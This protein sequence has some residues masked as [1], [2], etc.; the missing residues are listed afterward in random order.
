MQIQYSLCLQELFPD[1]VLTYRDASSYARLVET[2]GEGDPDI[3]TED[4][5]KAKWPDALKKWE[6]R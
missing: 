5:I 4:E 6:S 1:Q 3:P 2:W